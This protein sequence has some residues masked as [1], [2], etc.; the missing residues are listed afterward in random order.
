[1][2]ERYFVKS[3]KERGKTLTSEIMEAPEM[4][5]EIEE[6]TFELSEYY[7]KIS[8]NL[9]MLSEIKNTMEIHYLNMNKAT[10]SQYR[11]TFPSLVLKLDKMLKQVDFDIKY[12]EAFLTRISK[13]FESVKLNLDVIRSGASFR[14]Q[15][16]SLKIQRAS[17]VIEFVVVLYYFTRIWE[18]YSH[19]THEAL[20]IFS[21]IIAI[22]FSATV[23]FLTD[24]L[25]ELKFWGKK[26]SKKS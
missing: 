9:S 14:I 22:A 13:T 12:T 8:D 3:S 1:L 23:T 24:K 6:V 11:L 15:K 26:K 19:E 18:H 20:G 7:A 21:F 16:E 4:L 10:Q 5:E 2:I 17:E 25:I